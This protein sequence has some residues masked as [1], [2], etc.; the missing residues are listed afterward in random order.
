MQLLSLIR[1]GGNTNEHHIGHALVFGSDLAS[2]LLQA[3]DRSTIKGTNGIVGK[4]PLYILSDHTHIIIGN[5][6]YDG[7]S[8]EGLTRIRQSI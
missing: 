4:L 3:S 5:Q 8:Y 6:P 7:L 2:T 1:F